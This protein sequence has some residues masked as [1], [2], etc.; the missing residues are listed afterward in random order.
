M[1]ERLIF[2]DFL[3]PVA[4]HLD[5]DGSRVVLQLV[6]ECRG[7]GAVVVED[8]GAVLEGTIGRNYQ[9]P[10]L[11][12]IADDLEDKISPGL[13]DGQIAEFVIAG[14]PYPNRFS[15]PRSRARA[16]KLLLRS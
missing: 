4:L 13:V 16:P 11:I 14:W 5:D 7:E 2:Q 1:E 9:G 15:A 8:L 12:A 10:A 3:H 6:K